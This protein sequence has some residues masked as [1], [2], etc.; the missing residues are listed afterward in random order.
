MIGVDTNVLI[1]LLVRDDEHQFNRVMALIDR[2]EMDGP[3]F[4]NP[5]VLTETVWVLERRVGLDRPAARQMVRDL[6]ETLEFRV[7]ATLGSG[8]VS[9]WFQSEHADFFDVVIARTNAASGCSH[10]LTFDK[11]AASHVPGMVLLA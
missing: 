2:A 10:T 3:Y 11:R 4:L 5:L 8:D 7:P 6:S 1:R 9:G